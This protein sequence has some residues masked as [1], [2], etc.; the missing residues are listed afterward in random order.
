MSNEL[1]AAYLADA[2]DSFRKYKLLGEKAMAQVYDSGLLRALDAESNS[3]A[4]VVKHLAGNMRSRWTGFLTTDGE[5]PN[6]NREAEFEV[7]PDTTR[8]TILGWWDDGWGCLF[9]ALG[10]LKPA[11]LTRTVH[12]RGQPHTVVQAI[13]RQLSHYAYHIG[14]IVFLAKHFAGPAWKSLSIPRGQS[15]TVQPDR[16]DP[17]SKI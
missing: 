7:E 10:V 4:V 12:I 15:E 17:I 1:G 6:R 13:N 3:I 8:K 14:Q 2:I 11:D 9:D 16:R 5:K